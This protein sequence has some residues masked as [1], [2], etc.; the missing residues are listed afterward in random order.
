MPLV[1]S[2]ETTPAWA[3]YL[4]LQADV[5]SWLQFPAGSST[6]DPVLQNLLD[7]ACYWVQDYLGKPVA[8]TTFFRRF[9]GW[10]GLNGA[11]LELPYYPVLSVISVVEYWGTSGAHTLAEQ[12][13]ANQGTSD[14]YQMDY[15]RGQVIRTFRGLVQ[16]PWFP[17]S[18]NIEIEWVAGYNPIPPTIKIAT[19]ELIKY[20]WSNTQQASRS[21]M[22]RVEYE[23][24][25]GHDLWPAVPQRI[26]AL[27]EPFVQVGIG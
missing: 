12:T 8:P 5:K 6:S 19:L 13:P 11:Y 26:T 1:P 7:M 16:R 18:R 17:G 21:I 3:N 14:M 20:W 23:P 27:L 2:I 4:D 25:S 22:A 9:S 15:L 24:E 10:T